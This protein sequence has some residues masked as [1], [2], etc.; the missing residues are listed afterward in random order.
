MVEPEE[1]SSEDAPREWF[2]PNH[3]AKLILFGLVGGA[4]FFVYW[5]YRSWKAYAANAGY[6]RRAFWRSVRARTGYRPSP[7]WRALLL[8]WY[9]LCLFPAVDRECRARGVRGVP[10]VEFLALGFSL[11]AVVSGWSTGLLEQGLFSPVWAIVPVQLGVNRLHQAEGRRIR[12]RTN[13]WEVAWVLL[14]VLGSL[15]ASRG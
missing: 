10:V 12:L 15:N 2:Y 9:F 7:F 14:G 13:G 1:P 11:L 3:L 5:A 4:P 6:S 8:Q